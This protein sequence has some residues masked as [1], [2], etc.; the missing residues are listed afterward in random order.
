MADNHILIKNATK[1]IAY[2]HNKAVTFMAKYNKEVCGSSCHIH[3]SLFDKKTNKN[4]FYNHKDKYGMSD[5]FKSYLAGQ[6]KLLPDISIF[7]APN[8]NSYKRFQGGSFAPTKSV[9]GIDNRTAGF[10]LAA[11]SYTH[12]TLPTIYSV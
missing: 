5:I 12:L 9:W 8:I 6:I 1:E 11:V 7:L 2:K 3:N 10:R 4:L